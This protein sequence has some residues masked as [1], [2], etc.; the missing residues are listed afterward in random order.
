M[1]GRKQGKTKTET[2]GPISPSR[3]IPSRHASILVSAF[4][5]VILLSFMQTFA[6]VLSQNEK[7]VILAGFTGGLL[8]FFSLICWGNIRGEIL[9]IDVILCLVI[10]MLSA[11]S[12]HGVSVTTC[13][14]FSGAFL[15][16]TNHYSQ[17]TY[18]TAK[19]SLKKQ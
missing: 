17:K 4:L 1:S 11:S 3:S 16:Y 14:L 18:D 19:T 2:S 12:I 10:A 8:F 5:I 7:L 13:F 15:Y 9:W 6:S